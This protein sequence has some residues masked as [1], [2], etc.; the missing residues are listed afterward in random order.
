MQNLTILNILWALEFHFDAKFEFWNFCW[1][2]SI[3]EMTRPRA[4]GTPFARGLKNRTSSF[5]T[6]SFLIDG[7]GAELWRIKP[8]VNT[9]N[10]LLA[11]VNGR[12]TAETAQTN[13]RIIR[14]IQLKW[15]T[16][17]NLT[18]RNENKINQLFALDINVGKKKCQ[19]WK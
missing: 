9:P 6:I 19:N 12:E 3:C 18:A 11:L 5:S 2:T 7:I 8:N 10:T 13:K 15:T 14:K 4:S 17:N 16:K 1:N